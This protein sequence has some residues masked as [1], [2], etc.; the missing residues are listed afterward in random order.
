[1]C[2]FHALQTLIGVKLT[3]PFSPIGLVSIHHG[4]IM[5]ALCDEC[6]ANSRESTE[7]NEIREHLD[8]YCLE[9]W[10]WGRVRAAVAKSYFAR[11]IRLKVLLLVGRG[12]YFS[13]L[14]VP[15]ESVSRKILIPPLR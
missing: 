5:H 3:T 4:G 8:F 15:Q 2:S 7:L 13:A 12:F 10:K 14:S 9:V 6:G 1:L 11:I